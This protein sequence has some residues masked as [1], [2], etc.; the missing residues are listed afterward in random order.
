[1][2]FDIDDI[3]EGGLDFN[4]TVAYDQFKIDHPDCNLNNE[5][6]VRGNLNWLNHEIYLNGWVKTGLELTCSRCLEAV[7]F[8]VHTKLFARFIP[9]VLREDS[10]REHEIRGSD[11]E[12]EY[13]SENRIN[14]SHSVHDA[15]LLDVPMVGLC[16]D[17]CLGLCYLCGKN[18]NSSPCQCLRKQEIDP[19]LKVLKLI[20]DNMK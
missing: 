18:R 8:S 5:V 17:D 7:D 15:I 14:I 12:T 9:R 3:T 20:K 1:M 13:Y 6:G 2:I 4:L 11:L 19:R 16:R 10:D